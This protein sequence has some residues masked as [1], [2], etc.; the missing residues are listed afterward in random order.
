MDDDAGL[1]KLFMD[2]VDEELKQIKR[3]GTAVPKQPQPII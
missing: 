1:V 2:K 3:E